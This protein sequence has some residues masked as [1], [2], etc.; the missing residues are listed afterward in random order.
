M[1]AADVAIVSKQG[2]D[3]SRVID[4]SAYGWPSLFDESLK[5]YH[6]CRNELIIEIDSLVH[7]HQTIILDVLRS[8]LLEEIR[9]V[10]NGISRINA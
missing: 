5:P 2:P 1:S 9:S 3:V 4:Y 10:H 8:Q 6:G 7:G